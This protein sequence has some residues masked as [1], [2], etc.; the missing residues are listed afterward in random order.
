MGRR[1]R[2]EI[3]ATLARERNRFEAWCG[4]RDVRSWIPDHLWKLA[5]KPAVVHSLNRTASALKLDYCWLK[6]RVEAKSDATVATPAFVELSRSPE[7]AGARK[8]DATA[9]SLI[10]MRN[11]GSGM[12]FSR[13]AGQPANLA[14]PLTAST[15]WDVIEAVAP[16]VAPAC[17]AL[18]SQA[19]AQGDVFHRNA[20][21]VAVR[22][23]LQLAALELPSSRRIRQR[24][25][26]SMTAQAICRR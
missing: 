21:R 15:Q 17:E 19:A 11:Y 22:R 6:R 13:V 8:Y 23:A 1:K 26:R 12:P 20:G 2:R 5:V 18:N 3:P 4:A 10:A 14:I 9:G 24:A 7:D 16:S 25:S